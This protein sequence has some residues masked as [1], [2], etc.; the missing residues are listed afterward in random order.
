MVFKGKIEIDQDLMK[1][2]LRVEYVS[3]FYGD[4][5]G[6]DKNLNN[7]KWVVSGLD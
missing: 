2:A 7:L 3:G 5:N 6:W 4:E 1:K